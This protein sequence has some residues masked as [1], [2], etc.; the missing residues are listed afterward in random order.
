MK[1]KFL[2]NIISFLLGIFWALLILSALILFKSFYPLGVV[3]AIV[4]AVLST[5]FWLLIIIF[6]EI[7]NIQIEKLKEEKR[8]TKLLESIKHR[9]NE[10]S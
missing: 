4:I 8:Q 9:L 7:A 10:H 2:E 5:A 1:T 3:T 6:L